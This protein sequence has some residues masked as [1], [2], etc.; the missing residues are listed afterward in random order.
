V[1]AASEVAEKKM[2]FGD[3]EMNYMIQ[4]RV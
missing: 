1:E 4:A 2:L 3:N